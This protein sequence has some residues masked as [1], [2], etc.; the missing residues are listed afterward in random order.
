MHRLGAV[1]GSSLRSRS[2]EPK[3]DSTWLDVIIR[4]I[5]DIAF[6]RSSFGRRALARLAVPE[7][8]RKVPWLAYY[9]PLA[10]LLAPL[11]NPTTMVSRYSMPN[12]DVCASRNFIFLRGNVSSGP[13]SPCYRGDFND[14]SLNRRHFARTKSRIG[15]C[16]R[17][18]HFAV[19]SFFTFLHSSLFLF[20]ISFSH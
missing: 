12:P 7:R 15:N 18:F 13:S 4:V 9:K 11:S 5:L 2:R 17:Y 1:V 20:C 3:R 14:R 6:T 8:T 10:C 19:V 16:Y